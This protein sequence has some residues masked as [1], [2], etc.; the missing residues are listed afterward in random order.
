MKIA[1]RT[2]QIS[3][4]SILGFLQLIRFDN[5]VLLWITQILVRIFLVGPKE[6]WQ[7]H[8]QHPYFGWLM[9]FSACIVAGGFIINDYYDI[10]IDAINYPNRVVLGRKLS[11][12]VAILWHTVLTGT[13]ILGGF[14]LSWRLGVINTISAFLV[15]L[16]S[17]Q[18]KRKPLIGN[19]ALGVLA[20]IS[21]FSV[22]IYYQMLTIEVYLFAIFA[23]FIT[24]LRS[25]VKDMADLRGDMHFGCR[26]LPIVWGIRRT[27]ILMYVL[28]AVCLSFSAVLL[29]SLPSSV[30]L[31]YFCIVMLLP[32][33]YF[34]YKLYWA[35]TNRAYLYLNTFCK[36]LM[37][38]GTSGMIWA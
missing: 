4:S 30:E 18:L 16:Y 27:K 28:T 2:S 14:L 3:K 15:W 20:A 37:I 8:L 26:T 36:V 24:L 32:L 21:V 29:L 6:E 10:K 22:S 33:G 1:G 38:L 12:R 19:L 23:Y 13:G 17:N 7:A 35:D 25:L 34:N 31:K 5:L 9:L 11:R